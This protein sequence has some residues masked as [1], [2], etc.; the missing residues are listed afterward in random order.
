MASDALVRFLFQHKHVR[1]ELSYIND[2]LQQML[3]NHQYPLPVKQLL[4]ELVVATSLLTATLKFEGEIAMQLQG[5]GPVKFAAVNGNH[6]QQFRGVARLQSELQG[7][8]FNEL[9]GNG[10]LVVT[11]TPKQGERYQGIIPLTGNSLTTTLEAYFA[12]SE[13][14]PT[15]LYIFTDITAQHR[16][17]GLLLQV[18]PVEQDKAREDF[19]DLVTLSDTLTATELLNLPAEEVL[20]RLF[21]QEQVEVFPT[22]AI[23]FICGCSKEKCETALFSLGRAVVAEQV[24]LGGL[25]MSCEYCNTSYHFT[26]Q[27][28]QDIHDKL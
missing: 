15:R 28:L 2:S 25:D 17:A 13:Q 4:A 5:D 19:N 10:Y 8:S 20:Y 11:I 6:L 23:R 7:E 26:A 24:A 16:A 14:L 18:L 21:H 22:Q 27:D 12:Q 1:G 9:V 3:E